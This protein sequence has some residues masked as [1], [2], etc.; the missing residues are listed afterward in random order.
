MGSPEEEP[1]RLSNEQQHWVEVA[2]LALL[3]TP[4][5]FAIYDAYC[6]ATGKN[7]PGDKG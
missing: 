6:D 3:S 5:T 2:A 4:V 7:K 1:K